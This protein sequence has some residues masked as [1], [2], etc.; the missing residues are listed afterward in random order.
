[1]LQA[2]GEGRPVATSGILRDT[3]DE[4][5]QQGHV[6]SGNVGDAAKN[7]LH[8]ARKMMKR[9]DSSQELSCGQTIT[10]LIVTSGL[11][12]HLQHRAV[13]LGLTVLRMFVQLGLPGCAEPLDLHTWIKQIFEEAGSAAAVTRCSEDSYCSVCSSTT[14]SSVLPLEGASVEAGVSCEEEQTEKKMY[15]EH[16]NEEGYCIRQLS[17]SEAAVKDACLEKRIKCQAAKAAEDMSGIIKQLSSL[18]ARRGAALGHM[19]RFQDGSLDYESA[20]AL[21]RMS[22]AEEARC[23][24][25]VTDAMRLKRFL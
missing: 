13:V 5:E 14:G 21:A 18:L 3:K 10:L 15:D 7:N 23:E 24:Q 17:S 12:H 2:A 4:V 9:G 16:D 20:A 22:G 25:L 11:C 1:M 8:S 6:K 19:K